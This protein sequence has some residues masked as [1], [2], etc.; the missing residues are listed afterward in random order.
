LWMAQEAQV[1]ARL[2]EEEAAVAAR[3]A[4]REVD[5]AM[6]RIPEPAVRS[7]RSS[8][9]RAVPVSNGSLPCPT[10]VSHR[11]MARVRVWAR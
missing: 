11:T 4:H 7:M 9:G 2:A 10:G 8:T 1:E 5:K 3:D 6:L